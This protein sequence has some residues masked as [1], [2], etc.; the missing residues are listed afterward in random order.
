MNETKKQIQTLE[1]IHKF[2]PKD[3]DILSQ[4]LRLSTTQNGHNK[5]YKNIH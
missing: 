3:M 2:D 5:Y 1:K 4:L